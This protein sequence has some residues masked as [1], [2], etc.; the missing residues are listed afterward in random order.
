MI[1]W[2]T[3]LATGKSSLLSEGVAA[4]CPPEFVSELNE[5]REVLVTASPITIR[6]SRSDSYE[7]R[8]SS[9]IGED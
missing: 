8:S 1:V 4:R 9:V 3:M 2:V 7:P 5:L 6:L